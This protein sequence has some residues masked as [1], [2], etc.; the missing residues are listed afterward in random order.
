M[1]MA[2]LQEVAKRQ[3]EEKNNKGGRRIMA[4]SKKEKRPSKVTEQSSIETRS[5]WE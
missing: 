1:N 3:W 2:T 4:T 5:N